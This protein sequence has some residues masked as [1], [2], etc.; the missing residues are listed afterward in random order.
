MTPIRLPVDGLVQSQASYLTLAL[1][2]D[3][4]P[5]CCLALRDAYIDDGALQ[6]GDWRKPQRGQQRLHI[7]LTEYADTLAR[8]TDRPIFG[9]TL[10][11]RIGSTEY[12]DCR[13]CT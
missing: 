4:W 6:E 2:T 5:A 1:D 3:E 8:R 9:F 11:V 7:S 13:C 12:R 10:L